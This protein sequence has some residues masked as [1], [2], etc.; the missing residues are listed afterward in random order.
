MGSIRIIIGGPPNSGKSTFSESLARL[1][2]DQGFDAEAIDLDK[3]SPTLELIRHKISKEE[4]NSMKRN[5]TKEDADNA[6]KEYI[7]KSKEHQIVIGDGPGKIS[8]ESK[9]I[10]S[11]GTVGI[12]VC[13]EDYKKEIKNWEYFFEELNVKLIAVIISKNNGE[14]SVNS[15]DLIHG[16]L[17]KLNREVLKTPT[18]I[19]FLL[20]L[21]KKLD[22]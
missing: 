8:E 9:I 12:I 21:R 16:V 13:R 10:Y 22:I 20:L 11:S 19:E 7:S 6:K 14:E 17:V 15:N 3:A 18:L 4:R 2:Q 5:L 1:F